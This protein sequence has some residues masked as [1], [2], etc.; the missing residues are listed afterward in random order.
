MQGSITGLAVGDFVRGGPAA[1]PASW[2]DAENWLPR[3]G[4]MV[5][6]LRTCYWEAVTETLVLKFWY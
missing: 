2:P 6:L 1:S 4:I 3:I 5:Q